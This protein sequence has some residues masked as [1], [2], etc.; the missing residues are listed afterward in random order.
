MT[1]ELTKQEIEQITREAEDYAKTQY[2]WPLNKHG[3]KMIQP[4]GHIN[5]PFYKKQTAPLVKAYIAAATSSLLK[6][7]AEIQAYRY[8]LDHADEV[9]AHL[10]DF[11]HGKDGMAITAARYDI[12]QIFKK[13]KE[14]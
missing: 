3:E 2:V 5:P 4:V 12:Q 11:T 1:P 7:K 14:K 9:L 10:E 13:F 8:A 6:H